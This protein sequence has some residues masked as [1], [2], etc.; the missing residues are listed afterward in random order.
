MFGSDVGWITKEDCR[1]TGLEITFDKKHVVACRFENRVRQAAL[2][3]LE[4]GLA[5]RVLLKELVYYF[6]GV[7]LVRIL[8][9]M[10]EQHIV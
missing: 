9:V 1:G 5:Y 6:F 4:K 2:L 8:L 7:R 3:S 10:G